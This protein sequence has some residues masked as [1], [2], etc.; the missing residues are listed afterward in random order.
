MN[1]VLGHFS[2]HIGHTGQ[3]DYPEDGK[4]NEK[5]LPSRHIIRNS[6]PDL[7]PLTLSESKSQTFY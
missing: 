6:S 3:G 4:M 5:T 2:A 7:K 1:G